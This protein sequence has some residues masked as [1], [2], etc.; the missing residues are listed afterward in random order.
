MILGILFS[1]TVTGTRVP[2]FER[3]RPSVHS[4][5]PQLGPTQHTRLAILF[6]TNDRTLIGEDLITKSID[7]FLF[8]VSTVSHEYGFSLRSALDF[9]Q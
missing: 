5:G 2:T 6:S 3:L 7:R 4:L 9:L 8:T 1:C